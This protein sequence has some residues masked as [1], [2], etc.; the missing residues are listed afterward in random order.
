MI[1]N[2]LKTNSM[3]IGVPL[4]GNDEVGRKTLAPGFHA[5]THLGIFNIQTSELQVIDVNVD[6]ESIGQNSLLN[7]FIRENIKSVISPSL[8]I[9]AF[10]ILKESSFSVYKAEGFDLEENIK[11][12]RNNTLSKYTMWQFG[13]DSISAATNS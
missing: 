10:I 11:L 7:I 5:C 8:K 1:I 13:S 2:K 12:L 4:L 6:T 3:K 9:V